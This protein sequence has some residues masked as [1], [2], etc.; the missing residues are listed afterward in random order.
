MRFR[1][2]AVI[3]KLIV[4]SLLISSLRTLNACRLLVRAFLFRRKILWDFIDDFV[5][6]ISPNGD[7]AI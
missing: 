2:G 5:L 1:G 3:K 6:K 4:V 7:P